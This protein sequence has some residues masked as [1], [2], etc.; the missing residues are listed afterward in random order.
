MVL[1]AGPLYLIDQYLLKGKGGW[2]SLDFRG[3][4]IST[5]GFILGAHLVFST[6]FLLL[7][8]EVSLVYVHL[9]SGVRVLRGC[10]WRLLHL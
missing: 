10:V 3:A 1:L 8:K 2:I 5:Y 7:L 9:A 6:V 4:L